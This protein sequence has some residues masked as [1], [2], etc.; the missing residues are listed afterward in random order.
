MKS[1]SIN[2]AYRQA[3]AEAF[4]KLR[5]TQRKK[6]REPQRPSATLRSAQ[7]DPVNA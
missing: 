7:A 4:G 1:K 2:P 3:G 5:L 6:R